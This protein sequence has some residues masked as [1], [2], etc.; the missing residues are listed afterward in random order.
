MQPWVIKYRPKNLSEVYGQERAVEAIK[1]FL[2][3]FSKSKKKGLLLYGPAGTGKTSSIHAAA[4]ELDLEIMEFNA[5]DVRNKEAIETIVK[6]ALKQ[7]SLFFKQKVILLDEIDGLSGTNDRG[8]AP[9]LLPLIE[10]SVFPILMTAND[11]YSDKLKAIRKECTLVPFNP[12]SENDIIKILRTICEKEKIEFE[13][14]AL[15]E[16]AKKSEG[17]LRGAIN[18]LETLC[19]NTKK[20]TL[21]SISEVSDREKKISLL[22]ALSVVFKGT[23]IEEA[24]KA[25]NNIDEDYDELFLWI[26]E[27]LPKEYS[28]NDLGRAFEYLSRADV[29]KGRITRWQHWRFLVYIYDLFSGISCAK[30][31]TSPQFITYARSERILKMWIMNNKYVKRK[32]IAEKLARKTH[33]SRKRALD[34]LWY[35]RTAMKAKDGEK[36]MDELGL[37]AEE[38]EWVRK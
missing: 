22:K 18:D 31:K 2:I 24:R 1:T 7:H 23:S 8:G 33:T 17:D 27:N 3:N 12:L 38:I 6:H 29:F 20:L 32:A 36:V 4:K 10:E 28:G 9:A 19:S 14:R 26:E 11:A 13:E 15:Q 5:S 34:Q 35:L 37:E 25:L 21:S 16:L 30:D